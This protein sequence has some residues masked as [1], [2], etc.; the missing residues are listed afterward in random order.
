MAPLR[1]HVGAGRGHGNEQGRSGGAEGHSKRSAST[2]TTFEHR[3][4]NAPISGVIIAQNVTNAAAAVSLL[5]IFNRFTSR[6]VCRVG[7]LRRLYDIQISSGSGADVLNAY[8][9]ES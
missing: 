2:R 7:H 6:L 9:A 4:I 3:G 1:R 5:R 8:P